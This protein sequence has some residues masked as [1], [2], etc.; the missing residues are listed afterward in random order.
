MV[1][2]IGLILSEAQLRRCRDK[3]IRTILYSLGN[4][5]YLDVCQLLNFNAGTPIPLERNHE[6]YDEV[7]I[8]PQ[9]AFSMDYIKFL[10]H[11]RPV[12]IGPYFWAPD[13][14]ECSTP[15]VPPHPLSETL[16]VGIFEPNF[17]FAK[18][19]VV[20]MMICEA[21]K[22][23]VDH[24]YVCGARKYAKN[25]KHILRRCTLF[26][27]KKMTL[28]A[29]HRFSYI[30]QRY[31]NVVVSYQ[32]NWGLNYVYLECF[33]LGIPLVHNSVE[34]KEYG[35]YFE[36]MDVAA[37][38]THLRNLRSGSHDRDA[39]IARHQ[40]VL[41]RYSL[42]NP[43]H[44][45]FF[46]RHLWRDDALPNMVYINLDRR[47]D[48][49]RHVEAEMMRVNVPPHCV[50]RFTAVDGN[51][52]NTFGITPGERALM[53]KVPTACPYRLADG[54]RRVRELT[55][56][57]LHAAVG[58]QLSHLRVLGEI[59]AAGGDR[60]T[61]V[62][63]DDVTAV[64]TFAADLKALLPHVSSDTE[65]LDVGFHHA[66]CF[67]DVVAWNLENQTVEGA[68]HVAAVVNEHVG[69]RRF[70]RV[71]HRAPRHPCRSTAFRRIHANRP[72]ADGPQ[73]RHLQQ[74]DRI[75]RARC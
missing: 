28:E 43:E 64:S 59:A 47:P 50:R 2:A 15:L 3:G 29:R 71:P 18:A 30:M 14:L 4:G 27:D 58:N 42:A 69:K 67:A 19:C 25:L 6:L 26:Q 21:A 73:F 31:C 60:P 38:A 55:T 32:E 65:F 62:F 70:F 45:A 61:L 74:E 9:F 75:A 8:L 44:G 40:A 54:T 22:D 53:K 7:W 56:K 46:D 72:W 63:Q 11:P 33:H 16:R 23:V 68:A 66:A 57:E 48:R 51:A 10:T 37:A 36:G 13:F 34:L 1:V 12:R 41:H 39:Y 52:L 49:R 5:Y 20:P 35:Y 17:I 24:A